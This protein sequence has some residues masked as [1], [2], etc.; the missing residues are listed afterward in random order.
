MFDMDEA[1]LIHVKTNANSFAWQDGSTDPIYAVGDSG[2]YQVIAENGCGRDTAS[3]HIS[4]R[5]CECELTM[6]NAFTPNGDGK[7]D[8]YTPIIPY[9]GVSRIEMKIF[10]RWSNVVFETTDPDI[11]WDGKDYKTGKELPTAVYY[12]VCEVYYNTL[13]GERKFAKPLSGYIHLFR[14]K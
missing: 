12:Y 11:N 5:V 4:R 3:V 10:N 7:N 9:S 2:I 1:F 6:P 13:D 14:E 8:V